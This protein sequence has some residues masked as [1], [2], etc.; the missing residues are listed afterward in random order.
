MTQKE[1]YVEGIYELPY[2]N[3]SEQ[4]FQDQQY[5]PFEFKSLL[6][7]QVLLEK[8]EQILNL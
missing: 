4:L 7:C 8:Y 6:F 2:Q 3:D 1:W 5:F